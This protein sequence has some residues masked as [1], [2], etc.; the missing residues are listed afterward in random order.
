MSGKK[1]KPD[2]K[3]ARELGAAYKPGFPDTYLKNQ[4]APVFR[5]SRGAQSKEV[6]RLAAV[7]GI[8]RPFALNLIRRKYAR[9]KV[10]FLLKK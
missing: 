10:K 9:S 7:R 8:P 5:T 1:Y 6:D 3:R 4:V 2:R